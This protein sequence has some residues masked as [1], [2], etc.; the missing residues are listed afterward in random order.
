MK[1]IMLAVAPIV[2]LLRPSWPASRTF[3]RPNARTQLCQRIGPGS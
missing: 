2:A 1:K 3:T